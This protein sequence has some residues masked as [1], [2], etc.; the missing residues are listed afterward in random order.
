MAYASTQTYTQKQSFL[1][2]MANK[3]SAF[4]TALAE[5]NARAG[6]VQRLQSMTD[7]QLADIGLDRQDIASYVFADKNGL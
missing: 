7:R 2:A 5:A 1:A 3:V 4:F 6:D